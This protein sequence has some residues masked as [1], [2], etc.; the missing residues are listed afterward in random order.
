MSRRPAV[1]IVGA[2]LMGRWHAHACRRAGGRVAAVVD[3]DPDAAHRLAAAYGSATTAGSLETLPSGSAFDVVHVC[4]PPGAHAEQARTALER[5]SAVIVEKPVAPTARL[6]EALLAQAQK[7]RSFLVPVHQTAFQDGF[8]RAAGWLNGKHARVFD[9][10]ACSAGAA[11]APDRADEIAA[12]ILP[13]P[14]AMLEVLM[15]D[16]LARI[17]WRADRTAPGELLVS[18]L[19]AATSVRFLISMHARP[20]RHELML[21]MDEQTITVDLFHGFAWRERGGTSRLWKAARPFAAAA[22]SACTAAANLGGRVV[23]REPAYPGLVALVRRAYDALA[24]PDRRP[25][26]DR[27]TLEVARARDRILQQISRE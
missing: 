23:R 22:A 4:T 26:S 14:L 21:F 17:D 24:D 16:A 1:A 9:Y 3:V 27:H 19:A 8:R 20:P 6:T 13:H 2:G 18:G 11:D 25:F 15:P 5:G 10:R 12:E 7:A